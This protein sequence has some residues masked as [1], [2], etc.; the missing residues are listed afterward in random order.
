[1]KDRKVATPTDTFFNGIANKF[2]NNIYGTTKG[3][4][5]H[6]MLLHYLSALIH[7]PQ[8]LAVLDA[9]GGTG[10]MS[11]EFAQAG[12]QVT[13]CDGSEEV[14]NIAKQRLAGATLAGATNTSVEQ[15][16]ILSLNY[17]QQFD[18][19]LCHAVL[20]WLQEPLVIVD[21]L[22]TQLRQGGRLSL[23]FFNRD[24]ALFN[25][26]IWGNFDYIDAGLKARNQVR[27]NP[28]NAQRPSEIMHY[29]QHKYPTY[30]IEHKAGIRC[31]HDYLQDRSKQVDE[32]DK[33]LAL[34]MKYGATEPYMWLGKYF[35]LII[36]KD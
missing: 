36:K 15:T 17:P 33:I 34:E 27:L 14:L 30:T 31:F 13:L 25:N 24:A 32:Y 16:D 4:L 5:R 2:D 10:M 23:S 9:G 6:Q 18:V 11:L 1:M 26:A 12:H 35:H 20:E 3:R 8:R 29:I 7:S 21:K 22:F 19:V 28:H